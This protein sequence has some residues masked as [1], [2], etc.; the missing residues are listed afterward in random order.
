MGIFHP[1]RQ[2]VV[3]SRNKIMFLVIASRE[4]LTDM[5]GKSIENGPWLSVLSLHSTLLK[6]WWTSMCIS[7]SFFLFV[8][9][10][11]VESIEFHCIPKFSKGQNQ[12]KKHLE[13]MC[14]HF[15]SFT[16]LWNGTNTVKKPCFIHIFIEFGIINP[17]IVYIYPYRLCSSTVC[18]QNF[19]PFWLK[20]KNIVRGKIWPFTAIP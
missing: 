4:R 9:L 11:Q 3:W 5:N 19:F 2:E 18:T 13:T 7:K 1:W 10:V 17:Y 16:A 14:L 12:H 15:P 8:L 6:C 20:K